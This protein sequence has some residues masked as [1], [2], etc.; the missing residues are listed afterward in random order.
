MGESKRVVIALGGNALQSGDDHGT[1]KAQL[2]IV[3]KTC[4]GL[5]DIW[6]KGYE[7]VLVHG[8]GPQVGRI[9]IASE[10]GK[11]LTPSM[12]F[13]VCGAM[14]QGYIGYHIQQALGAE[15]DRRGCD[16]PVVTLVTQVVVKG[17]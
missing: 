6:E 15:L 13:D 11:N 10:A 9:I 2:E 17:K 7:I 8:N 14:S 1:S 3:K 4:K 12:P 5:A 16:S